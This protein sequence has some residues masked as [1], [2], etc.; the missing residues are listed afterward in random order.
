MELTTIK[1]LIS[2]INLWCP[3]VFGFGTMLIFIHILIHNCKQIHNN[4]KKM[5]LTDIFSICFYYTQL[6]N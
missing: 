3:T 2:D 4:I 1:I 6:N 5:L